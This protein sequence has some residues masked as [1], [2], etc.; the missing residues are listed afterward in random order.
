MFEGEGCLTYDK[1][2]DR[3]YIKVLMTDK[4]VVEKFFRIIELGGLGKFG[5]NPSNKEHHK[6]HITWK[7]GKRD[8][9]KQI[10]IKLYPFMHKRRQQKMEEFLIWYFNKTSS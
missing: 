10:V 6:D 4:D 2:Y 5:K 3:W 1:N 9:I 7:T 8:H